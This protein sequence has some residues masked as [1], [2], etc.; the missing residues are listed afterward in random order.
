MTRSDT[1]RLQGSLTGRWGRLMIFALA[2]CVFFPPFSLLG[3]SFSYVDFFDLMCGY[4]SETSWISINS[5]RTLNSWLAIPVLIALTSA[6][7][8]AISASQFLPPAI[9]RMSALLVF[10]VCALV[11]V[12]ITTLASHLGIQHFPL[13]F[14]TYRQPFQRL[15]GLGVVLKVVSKAQ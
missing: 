10:K 4:L 15:S 2:S 3:S 7:C 9:C 6:G 1:F 8:L 14:F 5:T 11:P 13:G 12:A